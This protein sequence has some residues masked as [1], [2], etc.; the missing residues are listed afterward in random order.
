[1][2]GVARISFHGGG[3][4]LPAKTPYERELLFEHITDCTKRHGQVR[5]EFNRREWFVRL[6]T[7][8]A[9][10]C[11][12]CRQPL[13]KVTYTIGEHRLCGQCIRRHIR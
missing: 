4:L 11:T 6:N 7:S 10:V 2:K 12:A 5:L 8:P 9:D 1:M 13:E 3:L